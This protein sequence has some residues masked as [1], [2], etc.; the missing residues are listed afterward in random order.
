MEL[1]VVPQLDYGD[2]MLKLKDMFQINRMI[3][4]TGVLILIIA[5]IAGTLFA[6]SLIWVHLSRFFNQLLF[7]DDPPHDIKNPEIHL[8]KWFMG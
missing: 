7:S 2:N 5:F 8:L 6:S 1:K 3:F 4:W